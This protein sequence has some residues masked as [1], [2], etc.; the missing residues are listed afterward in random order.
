MSDRASCGY[1]GPKVK[2]DCRISYERNDTELLIAISGEGSAGILEDAIRETAGRMGISRGSV[3][4]EDSGAAPFVAA[5][6]FEAAARKV[7][8]NDFP[9]LPPALNIEPSERNIPRRSRLYVP[10]NRPRFMEKALSSGADGVIL[11]LE[12]SV[13]PDRKFEARIMVAHAL[14]NL[15][16][17]GMEVMVRINQ[18]EFAID[19]LDW[20]V[21]QPVQHILIPKVE[22]ADQVS[23]VRDMVEKVS[24]LCGRESGIWLMPIIES[25]LGVFNALDIA[26]SVPEEMAALTLGLQDLSAEMG[27][28]P[29][30]GGTESFTAR[31]LIVLAARA[32]GIQP[33]DTVYADVKNEEGLRESV[34]RAKELGFV[35]KGCIHPQ[36]VPIINEAFLPDK[37]SLNKARKIVLAMQQAA[38]EGLGAIALGS[39]MI[40]PPVAKQA[41]AVVD[42]AIRLGLISVNWQEEEKE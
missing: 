15:D 13:S 35:G 4:V 18:G 14:A 25:P 3:E 10:G 6:R 41:Q 1:S 29:T 20:I 9:L 40:D 32:A 36:Q 16:F 17:D 39:K 42:N 5:A 30:V 33:I 22:L 2:S 24:E 37:T 19:D 23:V 21:P 12:D 26:R 31:S 34:K 38:A 7:L 11:D 28:T 27:V 8:G